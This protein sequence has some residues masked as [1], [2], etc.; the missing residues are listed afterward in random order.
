MKP[1][2]VRWSDLPKDK[3]IKIIIDGLNNSKVL[4]NEYIVLKAFF[5]FEEKG[6]REVELVIPYWKFIFAIRQLPVKKQIE[7]KT[8]PMEIVVT[9]VDKGFVKLESVHRWSST[10]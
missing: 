3:P 2:R 7:L 1:I 4:L 9:K 5:D 6:V 8:E 10:D